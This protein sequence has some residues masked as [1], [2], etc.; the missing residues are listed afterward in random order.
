[1]GSL[2]NHFEEYSLCYNLVKTRSQYYF[3]IQSSGIL[4]TAETSNPKAHNDEKMAVKEKEPYSTS[5]ER[6]FRIAKTTWKI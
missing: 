3:S 5:F 2:I 6:T 4:K 1:M